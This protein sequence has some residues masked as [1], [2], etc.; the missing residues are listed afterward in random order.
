MNS[1]LKL[2]WLILVSGL[3]IVCIGSI[4]LASE[5]PSSQS[6]TYKNIPYATHEQFSPALTSLDLYIPAGDDRF[7][8]LVFLHGGTWV[9]GDKKGGESKITMANNAGWILASVNYRLSPD[10]MHPTH[11]YDVANAISWIFDHIS[12]YQGDPN[13]IVIMGH[14]A[15]AH[16]ASLVATDAQY[17]EVFDKTP[18]I[19]KGVIGLDSGAYFLPELFQ[20]EPENKEV[21]SM[22]FGDQPRLWNDASP[23][24]HASHAKSPPPFLLIYAGSRQISEQ[25]TFA[26][27]KA[28]RKNQT[29]IQVYHAVE[30]D[31]VS[32][33]RSVGQPEDKTTDVILNFLQRHK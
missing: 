5:S 13:K 19:I 32:V 31:H 14:S 20:S 11:A 6:R 9:L 26:L 22:A 33:E 4:S 1:G 7:P 16:L 18:E 12:D 24:T 23:V 27:A 3:I 30:K 15:G 29:D 17:L 28:L 10:V 21:F 2:R 8:V 25:S